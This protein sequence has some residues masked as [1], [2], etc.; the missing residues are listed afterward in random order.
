[1]TRLFWRKTTHYHEER[2]FFFFTPQ[3]NWYFIPTTCL[4]WWH[5]LANMSSLVTLYFLLILWSNI[6]GY[7]FVS[8]IVKSLIIQLTFFCIS[9]RNI[10]SSNF[11]SL[12]VVSIELLE[13]NI[14]IMYFIFIGMKYYINCILEVPSTYLERGD[15]NV[16]SSYWDN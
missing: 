10:Q 11:F 6:I 5:D 15:S 2:G 12:N 4:P 1:M 7:V 13:N 16:D 9:Y 3:L 8:S 14:C